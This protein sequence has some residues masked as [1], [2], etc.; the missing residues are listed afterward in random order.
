MSLLSSYSDDNKVQHELPREIV[1][2]TAIGLTADKSKIV[3][4]KTTE[5]AERFSY[6]G[7]TKS[8]AETC[9]DLMIVEYTNQTTG[10]L[11]ADIEAV[12]MG[13]SMWQ[14]NVAVRQRTVTSETEDVT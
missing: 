11:E 9:Q 12:S 5:T 10:E 13:G 4:R 8:A 2:R 1:F 7:M 14:V 6:V 3:Y